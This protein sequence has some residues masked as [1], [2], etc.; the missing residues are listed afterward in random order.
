MRVSI[1]VPTFNN[2]KYLKFFFSSIKKNSKY[3][4]QIIFH[5]NDGSDGTLKF[6]KKIRFNLHIVLKILV[7]ANL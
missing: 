7:F 4:H 2:L 5:I 1:I 6:A 3:K